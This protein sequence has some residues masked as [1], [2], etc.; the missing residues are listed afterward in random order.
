MDLVQNTT[1]LT[2]KTDQVLV[3]IHQYYK[4]SCFSMSRLSMLYETQARVL[5]NRGAELSQ[6]VMVKS[7]ETCK[8][9]LVLALQ[10]TPF[11]M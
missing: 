10:L 9:I 3:M 11:M 6:V 4:L 8:P 7:E 1:L 5:M 2:D